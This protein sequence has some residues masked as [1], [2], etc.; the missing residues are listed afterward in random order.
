MRISTSMLFGTGTKGLQDLQSEVFKV[1]NQMSTGRRVLTPSDDPISAW[2][3]LQVSQSQA[4][5]EQYITNQKSAISRLSYMESNLSNLADVLTR[6]YELAASAKDKSD[7]QRATLVSELE[8]LLQNVMSLANTKDGSGN[9]IYAGNQTATK[10]FVASGSTVN[11]A[12][13]QGEQQ[14]R[15]SSSSVMSMGNNGADV[16]M[17]VRDGSGNQNAN[18][19]FETL[20]GLIDILNPAS[21]VPFTE[22][23][24]AQFQDELAVAIDHVSIKIAN[25]GTRLNTLD[26]LNTLSEDVDLQYANRLSELRDLDYTEAI[27]KFSQLQFQLEAAQLT[28]KQS[29][30]L[31]L[32]NIL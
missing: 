14:L 2:E 12:G 4:V 26:G 13:D 20:Q 29:S 17:Q 6:A 19:M 32:F 9:Y 25:A 27:S 30:Q 1:Q 5:N 7:T 15:V 22:A 24:R 31:S 11:Y 8:G 23:D 18:T 16:F 21:G 10:P 3:S 28:F